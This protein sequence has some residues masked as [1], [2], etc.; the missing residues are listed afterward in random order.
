[1]LFIKIPRNKI[2]IVS[3]QIP[4]LVVAVLITVFFPVIV[5]GSIVFRDYTGEI[6]V[7][8]GDNGTILLKG[9]IIKSPNFN[10][11]NI[12]PNDD[13]VINN[14]SG[15]VAYI[16]VS[17]GNLALAGTIYD[18]QSESNL[19][20]VSNWIIRITGLNDE[21]YYVIDDSGNLWKRTSINDILES[22]DPS[23]L[24][25]VSF[26]SSLDADIS[27]QS[28]TASTVGSISRSTGGTG[29]S[30]E[31][32]NSFATGSGISYDIEDTIEVNE[33][34][35][36]FWFNPQRTNFFDAPGIDLSYFFYLGNLVAGT[37]YLEGWHLASIHEESDYDKNWPSSFLILSTD[38]ETASDI[39]NWDSGWPAN[40]WDGEWHLFTFTWSKSHNTVQQYFDH[41]PVMNTEFDY[42][43]SSVAI[44]K[45]LYLGCIP[46]LSNTS[47][48]ESPLESKIDELKM[49]RKFRSQDEIRTDWLKSIPYNPS[50]MNSLNVDG[51]AGLA[52]SFTGPDSGAEEGEIADVNIFQFRNKYYLYPNSRHFGNACWSSPDLVSWNYEGFI[53]EP[54]PSTYSQDFF[55]DAYVLYNPFDGWFYLAMTSSNTSWPLEITIAR[56][57]SPIG[58]FEEFIGFK[59]L[60]EKSSSNIDVQSPDFLLDD[61]GKFYVY[62]NERDVNNRLYSGEMKSDFSEILNQ[63]LIITQPNQPWEVSDPGGNNYGSTEGPSIYKNNG[64]YYVLY[65]GNHYT[66]DDYGIG[67]ASSANPLTS[68]VRKNQTL[69]GNPPEDIG[70][71]RILQSDLTL[72]VRGQGH[73]TIAWSPDGTELYKVYHTE[74][75]D[76]FSYRSINIDIMDR[77]VNGEPQTITPTR[78]KQS[79][80][81]G[82]DYPSEAGDDEFNASIEDNRWLILSEDS[83]KWAT[84]SQNLSIVPDGDTKENNQ[85]FKN[86]FLQ[87]IPA[88]DYVVVETDVELASSSNGEEAHLFFWENMEN[89]IRLS[90]KASNHNIE[91]GKESY[92]DFSGNSSTISLGDN[93]LMKAVYNN[94]HQL[95]VNNDLNEVNLEVS[96][97]SPISWQSVG[98]PVEIV[99]WNNLKVGIGATCPSG[100]SSIDAYFNYFKIK[101]NEGELWDAYSDFCMYLGGNAISFSQDGKNGIKYSSNPDL[102]DHALYLQGA[103]D[104]TLELTA[105]N[106]TSGSSDFDILLLADSD[107]HSFEE[108]ENRNAAFDISLYK[109]VGS[110]SFASQDGSYSTKS[111][112]LGGI[113]AGSHRIVIRLSSQSSY[114][115]FL[116]SIKFLD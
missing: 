6:V 54:T 107:P 101:G 68:F 75:P 12:D 109:H 46:N 30:G 59:A 16:D 55:W 77:N 9:E 14:N 110:L 58:P 24:F 2:K 114:D 21:L 13:I 31:C 23:L 3:F 90:F 49:W 112:Q 42:V 36:Q 43:E 74:N 67:Y 71:S 106:Y 88:P 45:D 8:F 72:G 11:N 39:D 5:P 53:F 97:N 1:M 65:S 87:K 47:Q 57:K 25:Y 95:A 29:L 79:L 52:Q 60:L 20:N 33:G 85:D 98:S 102:S 66:S 27:L 100:G 15:P 81:S 82:Y 93:I 41:F 34:T 70:D 69:V 62:W 56:G 10:A 38:G 108:H 32:L 104:I 94:V 99:S 35:I 78:S 4:I 113:A 44:L 50:Y 115:G 51:G 64:T 63:T 22:N 61:D 89:Y 105:K 19:N 37:Y 76:E 7:T 96:D 26:D 92:A 48:I 17:D 28:I 116:D 40:L 73:G 103:K 86:I 80:P 111:I 84:T 18:M 83:A 91:I